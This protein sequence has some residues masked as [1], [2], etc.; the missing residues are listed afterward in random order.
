[1]NNVEEMIAELGK[2]KANKILMEFLLLTASKA[3]KCDQ[4]ADALEEK[5]CT[6]EKLRGILY[7]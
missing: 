2:E 7:E 6:V 4:F 3:M 5:D 1:M